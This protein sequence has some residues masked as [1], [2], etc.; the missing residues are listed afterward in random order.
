MKHYL[1]E[2]PVVRRMMAVDSDA[3]EIISAPFDPLF[4]RSAGI[5]SADEA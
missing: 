3:A 2:V 5:L 4:M 1:Q